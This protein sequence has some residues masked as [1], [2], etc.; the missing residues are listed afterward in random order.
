[1]KTTR[2]GIIRT[3]SFELDMISIL[4]FTSFAV[5]RV[6]VSEFYDA[7]L[8]NRLDC[9]FIF[10]P[11]LYEMSL[12][13]YEMQKTMRRQ[14]TFCSASYILSLMWQRESKKKRNA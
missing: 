4:L 6:V 5:K 14:A 3:S 7:K 2:A 10:C 12:L 9:I 1:M 8:R 11:P 13:L